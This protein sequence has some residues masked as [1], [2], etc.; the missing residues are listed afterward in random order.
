MVLAD[1]LVEAGRAHPDGQRGVRTGGREA[2]RR[3]TGGRRWAGGSARLDRT[4]AGRGRVEREQG[5][6]I[7]WTETTGP[8]PGRGRAGGAAVRYGRSAAPPHPAEGCQV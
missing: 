4:G 6:R 3:A 1:Q 8:T 2:G 5:F 7:H